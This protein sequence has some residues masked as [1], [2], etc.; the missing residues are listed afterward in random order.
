VSG[1]L[2]SIKD[3]G[4]WAARQPYWAAEIAS[5]CVPCGGVSFCLVW[6][7]LSALLLFITSLV[8][9]PLVTSHAKAKLFTQNKETSS[10][11]H[12]TVCDF[13][14]FVDC[15]HAIGLMFCVN[16]WLMIKGCNSFC[17]AAQL[18]VLHVLLQQY[19]HHRL[20]CHS[21]SYL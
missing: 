14:G 7:D 6:A 16:T 11:F 13:T 3:L 12:C 4:H 8:E 20:L 18:V 17:A 21:L 2:E 5:A 15:I 1:L 9:P 10:D 19:H